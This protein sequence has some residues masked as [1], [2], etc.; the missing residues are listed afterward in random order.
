MINHSSDNSLAEMKGMDGP[1]CLGLNWLLPLTG[2]Y[3]L[4]DSYVVNKEYDQY[5]KYFQH[6]L[7]N[8]LD[9]A[10][11]A[12]ATAKSKHGTHIKAFT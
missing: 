7:V 8:P 4:G 12:R 5:S 3:W 1:E 9:Q 6:L 2:V 11:A 10:G